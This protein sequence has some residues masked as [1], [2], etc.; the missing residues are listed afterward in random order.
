MAGIRYASEYKSLNGASYKLEIWDTYWSGS[1]Q[2]FKIG[3]PAVI[4]Y[5]S[6]GD[7]KLNPIICSSLD[8]GIMVQALF[9]GGYSPQFAPANFCNPKFVGNSISCS[10]LAIFVPPIFVSDES[11]VPDAS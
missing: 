8:F 11:D 4:S 1:V 5:D 6:G 10:Y 7:E 9:T 3:E 2:D